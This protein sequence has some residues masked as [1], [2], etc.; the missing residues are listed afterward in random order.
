[1][2]TTFLDLSY[3]LRRKIYLEGLGSWQVDL[4][5]KVEQDKPVG[6]KPDLGLSDCKLAVGDRACIKRQLLCE[7]NQIPLLLVSRQMR[8]EVSDL[9]WQ[10]VHHLHIRTEGVK[11]GPGCSYGSKWLVPRHTFEK[12]RD[13]LH[14][15]PLWRLT[16]TIRCLSLPFYSADAIIKLV[17]TEPWLMPGLRTLLFYDETPSAASYP[18]YIPQS[19]RRTRQHHPNMLVA[20][21]PMETVRVLTARL[22]RMNLTADIPRTIEL[23]IQHPAEN[24][25]VRSDSNLEIL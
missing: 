15:R 13:L 1:M 16:D 2:P 8:L 19:S 23:V 10:C 5:V 22:H 20:M 4:R 12:L 9:V 21:T 11:I 3:E 14:S 6:E 18:R 25:L 17:H 7:L 24:G